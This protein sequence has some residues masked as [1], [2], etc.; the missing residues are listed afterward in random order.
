M[1]FRMEST[2]GELIKS[3]SQVSAVIQAKNVIEILA[4]VCFEGGE[5]TTL[6]ALDL[7]QFMSVKNM[8]S[9]TGTMTVNAAS[10][11]QKLRSLDQFAAV[12]I[13]SD[14]REAIV[15]SGRTKWK[16]PV[17]PYEDFP[18]HP[19]VSNAK[20]FKGITPSVFLGPLARSVNCAG[21]EATRYFLMGVNLNDETVVATNGRTLATEIVPNAS[22]P[23]VIL[24]SD[25]V[26]RAVKIFEKSEKIDISIGDNLFSISDG[27]QHFVSKL[28]EGSYPDAMRVIPEESECFACLDMTVA[29]DIVAFSKSGSEFD[30][31]GLTFVD[32]GI[33]VRCNTQVESGDAFFE[34]EISKPSEE[35]VLN[36]GY[37][38]NAVSILSQSDSINMFFDSQGTAFLMKSTTNSVRCVVMP[39]RW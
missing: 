18:A 21:A 27:S 29:Q 34:A 25:A 35:I 14:G 39:M 13:E 20:D 2:A 23:N 11:F 38:A 36:S 32:G 4:N 19:P 10:L 17:L 22:F 1:Q 26:A 15:K 33:S 30:R 8:S 37:F 24:P 9:S 28:I 31:I 5:T 12:E 7:D 16:L 3:L 6:R